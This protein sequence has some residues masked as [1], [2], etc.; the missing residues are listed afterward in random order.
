MAEKIKWKGIRIPVCLAQVLF[1]FNYNKWYIRLANF[2]VKKSTFQKSKYTLSYFKSLE[3]V[4]K[5]EEDDLF[6]CCICW[7]HIVLEIFSAVSNKSFGFLVII[8]GQ[9]CANYKV[10]LCQNQNSL[11]IK[12]FIIQLKSK[13]FIMFYNMRI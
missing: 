13:C 11:K 4:S 10:Q 6:I 7:P 8:W 12:K 1:Y 2:V 9:H 5:N 3:K